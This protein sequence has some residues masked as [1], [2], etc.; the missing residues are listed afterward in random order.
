[1]EAGEGG[2]SGRIEEQ[3]SREGEDEERGRGC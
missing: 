2:K 3:R 1:M